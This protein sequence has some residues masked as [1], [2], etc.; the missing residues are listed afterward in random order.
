MVS[1]DKVGIHEEQLL[2][3]QKR[4]MFIGLLEF[5]STSGQQKE[6]P[7]RHYSLPNL[8]R[9]VRSYTILSLKFTS[10]RSSVPSRKILPQ[11]SG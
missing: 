8:V 7:L 1:S 6:K 5:T 4:I 9:P 2:S 11:P 3:V 10:V